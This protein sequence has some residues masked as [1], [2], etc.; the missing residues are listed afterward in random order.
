M[1]MLINAIEEANE[2]LGTIVSIKPI[3]NKI[4][5]SFLSGDV[6]AI[7]KVNDYNYKFNT[8]NATFS[9]IEILNAIVEEY[10]ES[11]IPDYSEIVNKI[12]AVKGFRACIDDEGSITV[13]KDNCDR[14]SMDWDTDSGW[15]INSCELVDLNTFI[16]IFDIIK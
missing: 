7:V 5:V 13:V 3:D 15:Y 12:N 6:V 9:N 4:K 11:I 14:F 2:S 8:I 10:V 1:E 16:T